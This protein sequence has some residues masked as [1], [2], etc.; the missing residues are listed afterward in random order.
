MSVHHNVVWDVGLDGIIMKGE[1]HKVY[2]NTVLHSKPEF[3]YANSIRF[4][5]EPEPYKAWRVDAPLFSVQNAHT[6]VFNN[7]VGI[8]RAEWRKDTPFI[9]RSSAIH[10]LLDYTPELRDPEN[11]DFRPKDSSNLIDAGKVMPG[12]TDSFEG[13]APDIGAYE[14]GGINWRPGYISKPALLYRK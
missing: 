6:L 10:N 3:R 8:I 11:F 2:N 13:E 9:H 1:Y 12:L 7:V 5:T 14:H 4:D